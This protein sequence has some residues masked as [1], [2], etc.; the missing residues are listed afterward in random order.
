L[1]RSTVLAPLG[2]A[3]LA[4]ALAVAMPLSASAAVVAAPTIVSA[5]GASVE[6]APLGSYESGEFGES[7]A[8]IVEYYPAAQRL[9][10]VNALLGAVEVL[11]LSDPADPISIDLIEVAG[12]VDTDGDT[13]P[14]G[15][16]IN[17]V[18]VRPDGLVA[19]AVQSDVKTDDGW[20]AFLDGD[21]LAPL[22]AL[23]VG[24]L[25][26]MLTFTPDGAHVL[27]AGE[28]EP[29]DDY[30]AD[31]L[32]TIG[33]I[34]TP[35]G[36]VLPS[37]ADVLDFT[38]FEGSLP[39][40]VRVFGPDVEADFYEARNLEPEYI[41]VSADST[42]AWATL[43][44]NNAL[45]VIDIASG[46]ITEIVAL[47][48]KDW[49]DPSTAGLDPSNDDA[50]IQIA[51]WPVLGL[52]QP[53]AI[54]SYSAN[55]STYLVTANEGDAREWTDN[56][57]PLL[58]YVEDVR[59]GAATLCSD[60]P[61]WTA[62]DGTVYTPAD[63]QLDE[64]LGRL[65]I[66]TASG[67]NTADGC[68]DELYS[69]GARSFSI[70]DE[71]GSLVFDSGSDFEE[72]TAAALPDFFNATND[73]NNFDNRSD[74][75]GP[76]P[77]GV[78]VGEVDGR[79][80]AFIGFERVGGVAVYDVT[81]PTAPTFQTYVNNRDF[82]ADPESSAV[83]DLGPEGLAFIPA[84]ESPTG[85][86]MLA[87][88]NEVS[89]TTTLFGVTAVVDETAPSGSTPAGQ[90]ADTGIDGG[91]L[92]AIAAGLVAAGAGVVL[93]TRRRAATKG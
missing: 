11:D 55:G 20:V 38:A 89:G 7:A 46:A 92:A 80:Y 6:M 62:A 45:A 1:R 10:V 44:E 66:S 35:A 9:F 86:A 73:E 90:L 63:L 81:D 17:S 50:G 70:W 4:C 48:T 77:E 21:T 75:K 14:V 2:T 8:E 40:G 18:T 29:A 41:T 79:T 39:A 64:N 61:S 27:V 65:N 69:H 67:F 78:A 19:V 87:V 43:Q 13:I 91:M 71:A 52:Y 5:D 85:E 24:A 83:G 57:D 58:R 22:G 23:R 33:L 88:G 76:E 68:F 47:G 53:D 26:D 30:S 15:A 25:P 82:S 34:P 56:A 72:I 36:K 28:G 3:A 31:P 49:S 16:S 54:A 51:N 93:T 74:D 84:A 12:I 59:V 60:F 32:G 37:T 42:T